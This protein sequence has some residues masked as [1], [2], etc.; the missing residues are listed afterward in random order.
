MTAVSIIVGALV[1][2]IVYVVG[3][4]ITHFQ[5][6]QLIWGIVAILVWILVATRGDRIRIP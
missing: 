4:A 2:L 1:A 5:H 6:E 3:T